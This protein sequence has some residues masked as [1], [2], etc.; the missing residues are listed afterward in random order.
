MSEC[1]KCEKPSGRKCCFNCRNDATKCDVWH[2][3]GKDCPEW[4]P[5]TNFDKIKEMSVEE[6]SEFLCKLYF[7][8]DCPPEYAKDL[9]EFFESEVN[10]DA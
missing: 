7:G 6:F 4:K 2:H 1:G 8:E 9:T 3:C 5:R 10:E